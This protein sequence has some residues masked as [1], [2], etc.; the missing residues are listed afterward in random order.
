MEKFD[1]WDI[2]KTPDEISTNQE[3]ASQAKQPLNDYLQEISNA[4]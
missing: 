1:L 2:S 4:Q 3:R